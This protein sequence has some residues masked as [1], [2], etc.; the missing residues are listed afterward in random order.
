MTLLGLLAVTPMLLA[1]SSL[2]A[3]QTTTVADALYDPTGKPLSG[4]LVITNQT[5]FASADGFQIPE[6][7][8][9]TVNVTN[10][11]FSVALVPNVGATPSG[12]SYRVSYYVG[13]LHTTETW[14]VPQTP[15]P[16][17]LSSV[18]ALAPPLPSP[19]LPIT[20][21]N[22]PSPCTANFFLQWQGG[23]WNCAQPTLA[24][25]P[26]ATSTA[27][28]A[29]QLAG[30]LGNAATFPQVTSTHLAAA[31]PVSQGGTGTG[32]GF[33][34][35]SVIFAAT[36]GAYTE[37][38]NFSWDGTNHRL[39]VG[40]S[41]PAA[42]LHLVFSG[43]STIPANNLLVEN[44]Y[45]GVGVSATE[46]TARSASGGY[47]AGINFQS[48]ETGTQTY[49]SQAT[50]EAEGSLPWNSVAS[51]SSF[52]RFSTINLGT[53]A[54]QMRL[55][56]FGNL[57]LGTVTPAE[58][59]DVAGSIRS[60]LNTVA[61]SFTPTFDASLGNTQKI[62]LLANV[63]SSTLSNASAGQYLFFLICQDSTGGRTFTW[64]ANVRGGMTLGAIAS[65]CSAQSFVFDGTTAYALSGGMTNQ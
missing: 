10:G 26:P 14:V 19:Q 1:S 46:I 59:L 65:K 20:Q 38:A 52:L 63:T 49:L 2:F 13:G 4:T 55:D 30:D 11:A 24:Q 7:N 15:N 43:S 6:G 23:G 22:P 28:G 57:G 25:L 39:G 17:N 36:G 51:A 32:T 16:A 5:T 61:F 50:I 60:A 27:L 35:G 34:A 8:Q 48:K 58:K 21:V 44:D 40:T 47:G 3:Q 18:R 42:A 45:G 53:L 37:D 33:S 29:I 31:L 54:E 9:I 56:S 62:T 41:T 64:P 12:T